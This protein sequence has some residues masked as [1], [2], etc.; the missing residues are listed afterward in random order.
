MMAALVVGWAIQSQP[1]RLPAPA[2]LRGAQPVAKEDASDK[3]SDGPVAEVYHIPVQ[4]DEFRDQTAPELVE[5]GWAISP[6]NSKLRTVVWER[7]FMGRQEQIS[8]GDL[9]DLEAAGKRKIAPRD[10]RPY[11]IVLVARQAIERPRWSL[12]LRDPA[13]L[14]RGPER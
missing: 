14:F 7:T 1:I 13:M 11:V 2:F 6:R 10:G 8:I 4:Y 3:Y 12:I 5:G 9:R